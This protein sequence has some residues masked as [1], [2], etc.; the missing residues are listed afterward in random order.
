FDRLTI[1]TTRIGSGFRIGFGEE[2]IERSDP[3]LDINMGDYDIIINE[4][5][6]FGGIPAQIF[7]ERGFKTIA[8]NAQVF[9]FMRLNQP[10]RSVMLEDKPV[11]RHDFGSSRI[12]WKVEMVLDDLEDDLVARQGKDEHD[13]ARN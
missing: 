5:N 6:R 7:Q 2:K 8:G 11:S 3:A 4:S 1:I 9:E 10:S 12:F 13:H